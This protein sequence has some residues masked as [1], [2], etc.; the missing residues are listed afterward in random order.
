M[1][2]SSSV[3][4]ANLTSKRIY[5]WICVYSPSNILSITM[6][7]NQIDASKAFDRVNHYKMFGK[8]LRCGVPIFV[9]KL[10]MY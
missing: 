9:V 4:I 3:V 2:V 1:K 10:I 7:V 5:L 8:M 6:S